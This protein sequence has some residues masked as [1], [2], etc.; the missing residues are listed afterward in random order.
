[1]TAPAANAAARL[2]ARRASVP[3]IHYDDTLPVHARREEIADAIRS[4]QVVIVSGATGS[5]KSTQLPKICLGIGRGIEGLIGHTQ[6]RRIAAQ[7]LANRI[8]AELG[9][10]T[11]DLVGYQVRFVDRTSPRTLVKL[12]T[13]GL[14]LR[15]LE[16]D[17]LLRRYDTLI[18]DEAHER[19]LNVDF[20]LGVCQRILPRRPRPQAHRHLGDHRDAA[21]RRVLR[22]RARHR[23]RGPGLAGRGALPSVRRGGRGRL[24]RCPRPCATRSSRSTPIPAAYAA[25]RWCSCRARSRSSR[26]ANC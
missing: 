24:R 7:A 3:P 17:P 9:T 18:V 19:N 14:L 12:M 21:L 16:R 6:P 10:T 1:M 4:H 15:E 11:G 8:S 26:R 25:T 22:R 2:A 13:D 23:R 5:G 20:L